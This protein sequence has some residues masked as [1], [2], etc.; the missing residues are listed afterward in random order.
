MAGEAGVPHILF[1]LLRRLRWELRRDQVQQW[2]RRR[3]D[4]VRRELPRK[5]TETVERPQRGGARL[6]QEVLIHKVPYTL[7]KHY[8]PYYYYLLLLLYSYTPRGLYD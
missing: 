3:S 6:P 2:L 1:L 8:S 4:L 7:P 5:T